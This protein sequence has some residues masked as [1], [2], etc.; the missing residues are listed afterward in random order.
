MT[1]IVNIYNRDML[2]TNITEKKMGKSNI[3][4]LRNLKL[5]DS[6]LITPRI[7]R[8]FYN[9]FYIDKVIK[10]KRLNFYLP[11]ILKKF[12]KTLFQNFFCW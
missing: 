1:D 7:L 9:T 6:F 8:V 11:S 4:N 5:M 3:R 2:C 12:H 10:L